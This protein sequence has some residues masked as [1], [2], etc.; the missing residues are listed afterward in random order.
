MAGPSVVLL[1]IV[2][3]SQE[4]TRPLM[5]NPFTKSR[6]PVTPPPSAPVADP[7][8]DGSWH[9]FDSYLNPDAPPPPVDGVKAETLTHEQID[10]RAGR[11]SD[12]Q[13]AGFAVEAA[14]RQQIDM[15]RHLAQAADAL[16]AAGGRSS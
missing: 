13:V 11:L 16:R 4:V 6:Q 7:R 3:E 9:P 15:R 8:G 14:T 5:R 10:R 12:E 1:R 2:L